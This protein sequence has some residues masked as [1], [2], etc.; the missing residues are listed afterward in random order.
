MSAVL[1]PLPRLADHRIAGV[2]VGHGKCAVGDLDDPVQVNGLIQSRCQRFVADHVNSSLNENPG[3]LRMQIVRRD[4]HNRF[5]A[6]VTPG[7]SLGHIPPVGV[8]SVRGNSKL[9]G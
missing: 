8:A 2:T 6:V 5:D 9:S 1:D 3:L 4:N 7:F